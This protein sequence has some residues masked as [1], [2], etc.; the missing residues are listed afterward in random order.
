MA[1]FQAKKYDEVVDT[2]NR[3]KKV[4][5]GEVSVQ[6]NDLVIKGL[7]YIAQLKLKNSKQYAAKLSTIIEELSANELLIN[8]LKLIERVKTSI[9]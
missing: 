9:L 3:Y 8:N 4:T 2:F 7:Y 6:E 1:Y 5:K